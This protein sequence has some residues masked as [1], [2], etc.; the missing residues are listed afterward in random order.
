MNFNSIDYILFLP[1]VVGAYYVIP[2]KW[3]WFLLLIASY[4]FYMCWRVEYIFLIIFSTLVD[5]IA[6]VQM[7]KTTEPHKRRFYLILSLV[8]NLGLL[9]FFKYYDFFTY[10]FTAAFQSFN[11]LVDFPHFNILLPVGI[12]FYTFQTLS[13]SIDVYQGRTKPEKHLGRFA[14]YV[15]FF[16]QLV[17]GP[18]ERSGR[19]LPQLRKTISFDYGRTIEGLRLILWGLFKKIVIADRLSDFVN[20]VY[21]HPGDYQGIAIVIATIFFSFQ[22]YCDFSAYSDIAI[23]SA[24]LLGIDLMVNFRQPFFSVSITEFWRR[25]HIS[26][27]SW[28]TDY[29]YT[30]LALSLRN[31]RRLGVFVAIMTTFLLS[32]LWHGA[33]WNFVIWGGMHGFALIIEA[34]TKKRRRK[35]R[36]RYPQTAY[37]L[38]CMVTTFSL[39]SFSFIFFRANTLGDGFYLAKNLFA[40]D[41]MQISQFLSFRTFA[42][43]GLATGRIELV[44][45]MSLIFLVQAIDFF[46]KDGDMQE[47]ISSQK[48]WVRW[49][50]YL[51][52]INL[53][54]FL[55]V[56]NKEQF[57]YFQF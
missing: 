20:L 18:I 26:L 49:S 14:L 35:W 25:W 3:R 29:L 53:I 28:F 42:E 19:L 52:A 11:V 34:L 24:K 31:L 1:A 22:V 2:S 17:A 45:S 23:G 38:L 55:G 51:I 6:G 56:F 37:T 33:G 46:I 27:Y 30:P 36:K 50:L 21:N 47:V 15:S 44:L 9:F 40:I 10:S 41:L 39:V 13:Y 12:S 16:P 5:Y 7:G 8:A 4:Y 57:I 43:V 32:G 48:Q 54:L